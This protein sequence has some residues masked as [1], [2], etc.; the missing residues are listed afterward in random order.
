MPRLRLDRPARRAP[1]DA[2]DAPCQLARLHVHR[3]RHG[4]PAGLAAASR[5]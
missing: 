1:I 3:L 2:A 5:L 4:I